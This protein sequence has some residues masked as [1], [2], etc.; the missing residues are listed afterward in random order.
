MKG[1]IPNQ[2]P[3]PFAPQNGNAM[4]AIN[5]LRTLP[6]L[7]HTPISLEH[8]INKEQIRTNVLGI[9]HGIQDAILPQYNVE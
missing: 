9:S 7:V 1:M 3:V 2:D 5:V 4:Y 6:I 8:L